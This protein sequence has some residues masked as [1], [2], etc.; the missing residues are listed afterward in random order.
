MTLQKILHEQMLSEESR[1][2]EA[3]KAIGGNLVEFLATASQAIEMIEERSFPFRE[4]KGYVSSFDRYRQNLCLAWPSFA[5]RM[6]ADPLFATTFE[7]ILR[8]HDRFGSFLTGEPVSAYPLI[9]LLDIVTEEK[10][11]EVYQEASEGIEPLS[12]ENVRQAFHLIVEAMKKAGANVDLDASATLKQDM[13]SRYGSDQWLTARLSDKLDFTIQVTN[14]GN[15]FLQNSF[16]FT[17]RGYQPFAFKFSGLPNKIDAH[18][19]RSGSIEGG[20]EIENLS[21]FCLFLGSIQN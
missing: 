17:E 12:E 19:F 2:S 14:F 11:P 9:R 15:Q 1:L 5:K 7:M 6:D 4:Y 18:D 16:F 13:K 10:S 21:K 8:E 3:K 20:F